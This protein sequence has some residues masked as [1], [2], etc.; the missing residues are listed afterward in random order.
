MYHGIIVAAFGVIFGVRVSGF[1][2]DSVA[3]Y[4]DDALERLSHLFGI[5][6]LPG[7]AHHRSPPEYMLNLFDK[8]AYSDGISKEATPHSADVVRG[9][10]DKGKQG[11]MFWK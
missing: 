5:D 9:F 11:N 8:V 10:P 7:P 6:K 1:R 4:P 2:G 3:E